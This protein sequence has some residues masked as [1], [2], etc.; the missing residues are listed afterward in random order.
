MVADVVGVR[1]L[2]DDAA[3]SET[4]A[5]GA[6]KFAREERRDA[7]D[8]RIRWLRYDDVVLTG[9]QEQMR[10]AVADNQPG[11]PVVQGV[12]VFDLELG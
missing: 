3:R 11:P 5:H 1:P 8:P 4:I 9:R 6:E 7:R 10:A 12:A 2:A